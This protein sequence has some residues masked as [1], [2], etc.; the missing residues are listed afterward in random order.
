[1]LQHCLGLFFL[2]I[3]SNMHL[4]VSEQTV[5][6]TNLGQIDAGPDDRQPVLVHVGFSNL[7]WRLS[8]C[9]SPKK[10]RISTAEGA[11]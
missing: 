8:S 2:L 10:A 1:M 3:S 7:S 9:F 11:T 5:T 6:D 4:N